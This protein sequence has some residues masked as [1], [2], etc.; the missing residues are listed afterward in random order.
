MGTPLIAGWI[1][2]IAFWTLLIVGAVSGELQ[3]RSLAAFAILW[4]AARF[5]LPYLPNGEW[6][7]TPA[8][9]VLDVVLVFMVL[10]ADV[11]LT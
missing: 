8:V 5:G 6:L 2:H 10:K 11:P 1:A 7:F 3:K 4:L 9:A